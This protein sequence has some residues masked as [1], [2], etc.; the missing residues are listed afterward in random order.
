MRV[1]YREALDAFA[2]LPGSIKSP[3]HHPGFVACDA[4]RDRSLEPVFFVYK[5]SGEVFY[6]AFHLGRVADTTLADIQSPYAYGGP[7]SSTLDPDFLA[8]AWERY[9]TWCRDQNLL[10][11]FVRFHPLLDNWRYYRGE[12]RCERETV[13]IDLQQSDLFSSYSPRVR[14]VLQKAVKNHLKVE[15]VTTLSAY[16]TFSAIYKTSLER[17]Q[18][19]QFYFFPDDYFDAIRKFGNSH[20]ALCS[21]DGSLLAAALFIRESHMMEYHLAAATLEGYKYGASSLLVHQA[22]VRARELGC[23]I[24]HL[25]GGTDNRPENSLF[26]FKTG[27]S[28]QKAAYRIGYFIHRPDV[29]EKLLG[30]RQDKHGGIE[31]KILFYRF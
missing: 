20:L 24:L 29:Y 15:W 5:M 10:A 17:L 23:S 4:Q 9:L 3:Y 18:A 1:G 27:F 31:N 6:H 7:L 21:K 28:N 8:R 12:N 16:R 19:D 22:G 25:G 30:E 26:F 13:W 11:E 2:L 14:N